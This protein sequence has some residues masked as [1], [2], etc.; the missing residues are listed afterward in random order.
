MHPAEPTP[1]VAVGNMSYYVAMTPTVNNKPAMRPNRV[2]AKRWP[3]SDA[4]GDQAEWR[5]SA[6]V[7][8]LTRF[9]GPFRI[10]SAPRRST[11]LNRVT[12]FRPSRRWPED[13]EALAAT[14]NWNRTGANHRKHEIIACDLCHQH[15]RQHRRSDVSRLPRIAQVRQ[16]CHVELERENRACPI[17]W[18]TR[19]RA[20]VFILVRLGRDGCGIYHRVALRCPCALIPPASR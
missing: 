17:S 16:R 13:G 12:I 18:G 14:P 3:D 1:P 19:R 2:S 20:P 5:G 6:A 8:K 10:V 7:V 4:A 15:R 11:A 9:R